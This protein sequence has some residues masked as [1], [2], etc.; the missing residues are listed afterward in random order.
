MQEN[1]D[2]VNKKLE[3]YQHLLSNANSETTLTLDRAMHKL[4]SMQ[5]QID[6]QNKKLEKVETDV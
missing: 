6:I 3:K 4:A 1:F 5:T 2:V